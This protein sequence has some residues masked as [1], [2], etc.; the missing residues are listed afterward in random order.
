[1]SRRMLLAEGGERRHVERYGFGAA[2]DLLLGGLCVLRDSGREP[3]KLALQIERGL[4]G[5][6]P[7]K[8]FI[9]VIPPPHSA[10]ERRERRV[11]LD[12]DAAPAREIERERHVV[13]DRMAAADVDVEAV[14]HVP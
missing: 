10:A 11:W 6:S 13:I 9:E 5:L 12:G 8:P 3:M 4:T 1:M 2:V 14:R 7:A